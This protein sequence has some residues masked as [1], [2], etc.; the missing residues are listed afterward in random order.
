MNMT[1]LTPTVRSWPLF[2]QRTLTGGYVRCSIDVRC[3][4]DEPDKGR[5]SQYVFMRSA[6]VYHNCLQDLSI[7]AAKPTRTVLIMV[8][9]VDSCFDYS[10]QFHLLASYDPVTGPLSVTQIGAPL[11]MLSSSSDF[12]F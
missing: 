2:T 12:L 1:C 3:S 7:P 6:I 11:F 4:T 8:L 5:W 9:L 10:S